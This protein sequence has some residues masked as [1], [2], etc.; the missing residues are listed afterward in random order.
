MRS[1]RKEMIVLFGSAALLLGC[2]CSVPG[3]Y[4]RSRT[5]RVY[6]PGTY[7]R[8]RDEMS[9]RAALRAALKKHRRAA[10]KRR[11]LLH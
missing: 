4:A 1:L 8:T 5:V 6:R 9:R 11:H 2:L 10:R 3:Q 7:S